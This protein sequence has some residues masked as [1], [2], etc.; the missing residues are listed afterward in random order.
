MMTAFSWT[1]GI[2]DERKGSRGKLCIGESCLHRQFNSGCVF[3]VREPA[4]TDTSDTGVGWS[5][6]FIRNGS[7]IFISFRG[8]FSDGREPFLILWNWGT[9]LLSSSAKAQTAC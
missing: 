7:E 1:V 6:A 3:G 5:R 4:G 8:H 9:I 2:G